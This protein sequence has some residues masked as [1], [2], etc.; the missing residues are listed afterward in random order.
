MLLLS[1]SLRHY[2]E[3][4][5]REQILQTLYR[6]LPYKFRHHHIGARDVHFVTKLVEM[7]EQMLAGMRIQRAIKRWRI[8]T[9]TR[10]KKSNYVMAH[11]MP[12]WLLNT[13]LAVVDG[14][15]ID[16][17][18]ALSCNQRKIML[19]VHHLCLHAVAIENRQRSQYEVRQC[20]LDPRLK[21]PTFKTLMAKMITEL[22]T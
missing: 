5:Y 15:N 18:T 7:E 22:S 14:I 16:D 17:K 9:A 21:P 13:T 11:N 19:A 10:R 1:E 3:A 12:K 6:H 8:K 2:C 20:K 4:R